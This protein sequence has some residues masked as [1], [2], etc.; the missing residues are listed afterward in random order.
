VNNIRVPLSTV[1]LPTLNKLGR[2]LH[3]FYMTNDWNYF[4]PFD[5]LLFKANCSHGE[6][7]SSNRVTIS[8]WRKLVLTGCVPSA[9]FVSPLPS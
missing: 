1:I 7:V 6:Q 8:C 5:R 3:A 4:V 9:L 2:Y